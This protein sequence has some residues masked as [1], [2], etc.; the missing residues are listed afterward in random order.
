MLVSLAFRSSGVSR[1]PENFEIVSNFIIETLWDRI[2]P[3]H[4]VYP[5]Q[6]FPKCEQFGS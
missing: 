4:R 5:A 1:L 3:T 6:Y 2:R